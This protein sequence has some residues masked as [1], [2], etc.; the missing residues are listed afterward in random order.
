M[1]G[2]ACMHVCMYTCY[3]KTNNGLRQS[4]IKLVKYLFKLQEVY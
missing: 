3:I 4:T 1:V 2:M